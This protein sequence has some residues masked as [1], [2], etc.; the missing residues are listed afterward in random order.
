MIR[1][2]VSLKKNGLMNLSRGR[3]KKLKEVAMKLKMN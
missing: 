2:R 1:T 3:K